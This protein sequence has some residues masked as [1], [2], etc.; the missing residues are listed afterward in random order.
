M[1]LNI[2]VGPAVGPIDWQPGMYALYMPRE[3][4]GNLQHSSV[5]KGVVTSVNSQY[6]FVRFGGDSQSKACHPRDL[7]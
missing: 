4:N 7:H 5:E 6:V 2:A 3:A 1:R